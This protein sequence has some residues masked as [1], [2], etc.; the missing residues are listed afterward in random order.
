MA[1][2]R[3]PRVP[4][5][6]TDTGWAGAHS[7]TPRNLKL[8]KQEEWKTIKKEKRSMV[9]Q[10][11]GPDSEPAALSSPHKYLLISL[12]VRQHRGEGVIR[13]ENGEKGLGQPA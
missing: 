3:L 8:L 11:Q 4:N 13:P 12:T 6:Q 5:I 10:K 7:F 9:T 1:S 2:Q